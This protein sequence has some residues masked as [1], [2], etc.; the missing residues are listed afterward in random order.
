MPSFPVTA[1][2]T[3][4]TVSDAVASLRA[5]TITG[6]GLTVSDSAR[7]TTLSALTDTGLSLGEVVTPGLHVAVLVDNGLQNGPPGSASSILDRFNRANESPLSG[8]GNW[9]HSFTVVQTLNLV[10]N[11]VVSN[12]IPGQMNWVADGAQGDCE[13]YCTITQLPLGATGVVGVVCRQLVSSPT[14]EAAYFAYLTTSGVVVVGFWDFSGFAN[15][16]AVYTLSPAAQVGDKIALQI[17]GDNN[18]GNPV[19]LKTWYQSASG[20]GWRLLGTTLSPFFTLNNGYIG[21]R[22]GSTTA[23]AADDFGGGP[24]GPGVSDSIAAKKINGRVIA[25]TGLSVTDSIRVARRLVEQGLSLSESIRKTVVKPGLTDVGLTLTDSLGQILLTDTGLSFSETLRVVRIR[26]LSAT[27]ATIT[28]TFAKTA[29]KVLSDVGIAAPFTSSLVTR[30][31]GGNAS[32]NL[33]SV[34]LALSV[35][36]APARRYFRAIPN[37]LVIP[38]RGATITDAIRRTVTPPQPPPR[39]IK[40]AFSFDTAG[41][42]VNFTDLST[43]G[44]SGPIVAWF[45]TFGDGATSTAQNPS[46]TYAGSGTYSVSLTVTGTGPDGLAHVSHLVSPFV[47]AAAGFHIDAVLV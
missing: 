30:K 1:T 22:I 18:T 32:V 13:A 40:A 12:G 17:K 7:K 33:A 45:W 25:D 6:T 3:G 43:P 44:P 2:D 14:G 38:D 27:G 29:R 34:G 46:H 35:S 39:R 21:L 28:D 15:S 26:L 41:L 5:R 42:T 20:G 37:T 4:L 10:S 31:N 24:L 11:Q 19:T 47:P 23:G 36:L 9:G 16:F 8:G